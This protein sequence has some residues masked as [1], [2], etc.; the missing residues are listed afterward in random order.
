MGMTPLDHISALE[1]KGVSIKI[2]IWLGFWE[3]CVLTT[4]AV[5]RA[6]Y[7]LPMHTAYREPTNISKNTKP[8]RN[9]RTSYGVSIAKT[10][11]QVDNKLY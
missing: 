7:T 4:Q 9:G 1:Y 8:R 3:K 11:V 5:P 2:R 6:S 10:V